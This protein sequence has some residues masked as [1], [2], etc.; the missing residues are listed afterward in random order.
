[1]GTRSSLLAISGPTTQCAP[2]ASCLWEWRIWRWPT[3]ATLTST[4]FNATRPVAVHGAR[5]PLAKCKLDVRRAQACVSSSEAPWRPLHSGGGTRQ[6]ALRAM[7]FSASLELICMAG[8][9]TSTWTLTCAVTRGAGHI[10][11]TL[12]VW[13]RRC[14]LE[15]ASSSARE[16]TECLGKMSRTMPCLADSTGRTT[17]TSGPTQVMRSVGL[18]SRPLGRDGP[19]ATWTSMVTI[20]RACSSAWRPTHLGICSK[21]SNVFSAPGLPT[22]LR[23]P[24]STAVLVERSSP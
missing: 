18:R 16:G 20:Y 4:I 19:C 8:M 5:I 11:C 2:M 17:N 10:A 15:K 24:V 22:S 23:R 13:C 14:V 12:L 3:A 21:E 7:W 1:M 6:R 9:R